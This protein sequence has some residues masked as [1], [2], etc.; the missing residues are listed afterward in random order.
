MGW[1]RLWGSGLRK[2]RMFIRF[3]FGSWG[4]GEASR[5]GTQFQIKSSD[6]HFL[7]RSSDRLFLRQ[8]TSG[9]CFQWVLDAACQAVEWLSPPL[10]VNSLILRRST[11]LVLNVLDKGSSGVIIVSGKQRSVSTL[12]NS[13]DWL[14]GLFRVEPTP[15][16]CARFT[17]ACSSYSVAI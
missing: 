8:S 10:G 4:S 7:I 5:F 17:A 1:G 14:S 15:G 16:Q 3:C 13:P 2:G 9:G 12:L 11:R 6:S